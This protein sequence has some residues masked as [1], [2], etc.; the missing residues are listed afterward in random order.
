MSGRCSGVQQRVMEI[1]PQAIYIHC[2][3]HVLN[4]VLVDCS[5]NVS[6]A[7]EFFAVLQSLY[8]FVSSSKAHVFVRSQKELHPD[9]PARELQQLSDTRWTCRTSAVDI[10]RTYD[11]VL[12]KLEEIVDGEDSAKA[13][14]EKGLLF[15]VRSFTF[16]ILLIMFDR[17]LSCTKA[18]SDLLQIHQCDLPK[19]A[20]LLAVTI[21]RC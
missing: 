18:L 20:D 1:V 13:V 2:F 19:A 8:V 7:V 5:K 9:K 11:A 4:L 17:I 3:A 14:E 6:Y 10:C 21:E 12:A 15:Q 16:F